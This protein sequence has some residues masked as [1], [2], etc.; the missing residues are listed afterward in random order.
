MAK[1]EKTIAR[2]KDVEKNLTPIVAEKDKRL[3]AIRVA[4]RVLTR[5]RKV[6]L[7]QAR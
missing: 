7:G 1:F 2:L 5:R 6:L 4:I 3:E